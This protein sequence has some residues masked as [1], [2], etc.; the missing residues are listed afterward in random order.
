MAER[1]GEVEEMASQAGVG[2]D[3]QSPS[4]C[5]G[6]SG[7]EVSGPDQLCVILLGI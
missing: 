6:L 5:E 4:R 3:S 7:T 2:E 1:T